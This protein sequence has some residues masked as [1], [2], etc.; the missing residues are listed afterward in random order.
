MVYLPFINYPMSLMKLKGRFFAVVVALFIM[1]AVLV[2]PTY[3]HANLIQ[4]NPEANAILERSPVQ[5]E[6]FFSEPVVDSFSTIEVIDTEGKRVDN[7]DAL[8]DPADQTRMTVSIRSL[9]EGIY[10]VSWRALSQVDSHITA[11]VFPFG[12]GDIDPNEIPEVSSIVKLSPGEI[13]A[14]WATFLSTMTLVGS[15]LFILMV[16]DP[17][18]KATKVQKSIK[19]PWVWLS[20]IALLVLLIA[21]AAWLLVQAGQATGREITVPW[22]TSVTQVL[23][24]TRFGGQWSAR[25]FLAITL[26]WLVP[27]ANTRRDRWIILGLSSLILLTISYGSHAA[28]EPSPFLPIL[29]DWIHL[30]A[31]SVW[32]GSLVHF[33]ISL[34]SSRDLPADKRTKL[35]ALLIPRFSNLA[36]VSVALLVI[37]GVYTSLLHVSSFEALSGTIYGQTLLVKIVLV[38]PMLALGGVNLV[39]TTPQ[40]KQA[41]EAGGNESLV[42]RFRRLI[43]SEITLG[44][45]VF[46]TVA[47][48]TTL[49]PASDAD[50]AIGVLEMGEADDLAITLNIVPGRVGLNTYTVTVEKDGEPL[51]NARAVELQFTPATS[52]LPPNSAQL[53]A[54]GNGEYSVQGAFFAVPDAWQVQVQVRRDDA[55]D[56]FTNFD[57]NIGASGASSVQTFPWHRVVGI[58]MLFSSVALVLAVTPLVR[59]RMQTNTL[60]RVPAGLLGLIG[61]FVIFQSPIPEQGEGLVNPIPPNAESLATGEALYVENCLPCHGATGAGDGPVGRTLNPPPAD[62]VQHTIPGVHPD[63]RLW[64]WI[65]FGLED[66]VMPSF[67]QKL[68]DDERW[69]IVNYIRTFAQP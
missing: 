63:S 2:R 65:T 33:A 47:V 64:T 31:V 17:S 5:V 51:N 68:S 32:V 34:Y 69:H 30:I 28:A 12:V 11:G 10:T 41:A 46:L 52:E 38:L 36:I 22:D 37:T 49:P 43:H 66:S 42:T 15:T 55:F 13:V 53:T 29:A 59:T 25:I 23:F 24:A 40:M 67:E 20:T 62:L 61:V 8:V 4:S 6:I 35:T 7:D 45:V 58:F 39:M 26:L 21:T 44:V 9:P 54:Q 16:W 50:A 3:A 56:A 18:A 1:L 19:P 48:L 14:R 60:V 27:R 57:L